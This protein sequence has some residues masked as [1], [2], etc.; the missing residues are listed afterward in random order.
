LTHPGKYF[1]LDIMAVARKCAEV[2]TLF[3]LNP[4]NLPKSPFTVQQFEEMQKIPNLKFIINTDAHRGEIG[5][6]NKVEEF[7]K[8]CKYDKKKIV[9]LTE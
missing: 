7:L 9:N 1:P 8:L 2:G 3:E 4:R 6:I 5:Q